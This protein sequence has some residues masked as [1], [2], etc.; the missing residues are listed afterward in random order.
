MFDFE[1]EDGPEFVLAVR[2]D[3]GKTRPAVIRTYFI[4]PRPESV[5][6]VLCATLAWLTLTSG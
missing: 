2:K 3:L 1:A 6:F 5:L 4:K